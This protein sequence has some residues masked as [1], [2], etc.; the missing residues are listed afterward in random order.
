[1]TWLTCEPARRLLLRLDDLLADSARCND[2]DLAE[3]ARHLLRRR[4]KR[5]RP[6]LLFVAAGFGPGGDERALLRAAAAIELLH[7]ATLYHDDVMDRADTRRGVRTANARWGDA[8]AVTAGT[9]LFA[10]ATR[11]L[12]ELDPRVARWAGQGAVELA[13]GQLQETESAYDLDHQIVSYLRVAA[14]KTGALFE[15]PCRAGALLGGAGEEDLECLAVYGRALGLAFQAMDDV[16]DFTA[17]ES[18]LGKRLGTDL[19]EGVYGLP[20]LIALQR[21]GAAEL[22]GVLEIDDPDDDDLA[23]AHGLIAESGALTHAR[24]V[25]GDY[26]G[27]AV[28]AALRLPGGPARQSL[29]DLS[30]YVLLRAN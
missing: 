11:L 1:M 27:Q 2:A 15:L 24:A 14:R 26:S 28:A 23:R 5:L 7:L 18:A 22:R 4:G 29:I 10:R 21:P 19:R 30:Q 16:L 8:Q 3:V 9:F 17:D 6:A 25:A 12:D 20:V 13:L